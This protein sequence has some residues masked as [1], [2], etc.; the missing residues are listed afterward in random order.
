M[1]FKYIVGRIAEIGTIAGENIIKVDT[2]GRI[3]NAQGV[4]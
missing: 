3:M 2:S 4:I 1:K